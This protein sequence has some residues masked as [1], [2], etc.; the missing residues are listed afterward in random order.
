MDETVSRTEYSDGWLFL[1]KEKAKAFAKVLGIEFSASFPHEILLMWTIHLTEFNAEPH[2][3]GTRF[4]IDY[5][6][7][8]TD[9]AVWEFYLT[10]KLWLRTTI[11]QKVMKTIGRVDSGNSVRS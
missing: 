2:P 3:F 7:V 10:L 8:D 5:M 11:I 1:L 6:L 9:I 4:D